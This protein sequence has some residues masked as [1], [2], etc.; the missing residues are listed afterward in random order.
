M[1]PEIGTPTGARHFPVPPATEQTF[2]CLRGPCRF[3]W[4]RE[5]PFGDG[6]HRQRLRVCTFGPQAVELTD[7]NVLDCNRHEPPRLLRRLVQVIG[8]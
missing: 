1:A 7:G 2:V 4:E 3:Y 6:L 8:L 5:H